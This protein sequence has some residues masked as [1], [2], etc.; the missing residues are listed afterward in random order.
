VL[1]SIIIVKRNQTFVM[2]SRKS[3][4]VFIFA[5]SIALP[6]RASLVTASTF[7][8]NSTDATTA[9]T[10]AFQANA[11]TLVIDFQV[12]PWI[13]GPI[14]VFNKN[15]YTIIIQPNVIIRA[16]TGYGEFDQVLRFGFNNTNIKIIGYGATIQMLKN[17]YTS[18]DFRHCLDVSGV[19]GFQVYG[20]TCKDS[21]GDGII[22]GPGGNP[23]ITPSRNVI[24]KDCVLDNNRR[25]GISVTAAENVL[26]DRCI[27]KNTNGTP[28]A[29]G[30]D[31]E[32]FRPE[33]VFKNIVVSNCTMRDNAG[34]GLEIVAGET[35]TLQNS[36]TVKNVLVENNTRGGIRI[37]EGF[38]GVEQGGPDL[39]LCNGAFEFSE[40]WI[41]NSGGPGLLIIKPA[42]S[43]LTTFRNC[44]FEN[45]NNNQTNPTFY[46][47]TEAT[48][49]FPNSTRRIGPIYIYSYLFAN[50]NIGNNSLAAQV[51]YG[52][53]NFQNC[54]V[55]D[56]EPRAYI[57]TFG[58]AFSQ[59][60]AYNQPLKNLTGNILLVNPAA[61]SETDLYNNIPSFNQNVTL[62]KNQ[63]SSYPA[64]IVNLSASDNQAFEGSAD[65][66]VFRFDRSS[67]ATNY[68]IAISYNAAG[69][70]TAFQ[71]YSYL[72]SFSIIK[73]NETFST[74]TVFALKDDAMEPTET[75]VSDLVNIPGFYTNGSNISG[76]VNIGAITLGLPAKLISLRASAKNEL[77]AL[78]KFTLSNEQDAAFY[79]LERMN[80]NGAIEKRFNTYTRSNNNSTN[81]YQ[82]LD[83]L[84]RPGTYIYRLTQFDRD[85]QKHVLGQA[86]IR[87]G[88]DKKWIISP[89]P[90]NGQQILVY[91]ID[92]TVGIKNVQLIAPD[93][94]NI[95]IQWQINGSNAINVRPNTGISAGLYY[96]HLST[97]KDQA[98]IPVNVVQ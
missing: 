50:T 24:I 91:G 46:G 87:F 7:G 5:F 32:P 53:L 17:E 88:S 14:Q 47:E 28:P 18:G 69:T 80:A 58:E 62:Q 29:A 90:A 39:F 15:N 68:P 20:L 76:T 97:N 10:N 4:L 48:A 64:S 60:V 82:Q 45:N 51:K 13:T 71:D 37:V 98:T 79:Q 55:V 92:N 84:P 36:V 81:S 30:I 2:I 19:N 44:I 43:L 73:A 3:V 61:S 56:D 70:A 26:I 57:S 35:Q 67:T 83:S 77:S 72:P 59:N 94:K 41:R 75:V 22:I 40:C 1:L 33:H 65:H 96:L 9:L 66:G 21:G 8:Y 85:G 42:D 86:S 27:M 12:T 25:Q 31:I 54:V 95:G 89:N 74:D 49:F 34:Y 52:G 23:F 6:M 38:F 63:V 93:G 11:D 78:V 16:R